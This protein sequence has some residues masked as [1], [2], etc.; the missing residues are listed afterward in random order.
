[1]D[2]NLFDLSIKLYDNVK[3]NITYISKDAEAFSTLIDNT[4]DLTIIHGAIQH[5]RNHISR[6]QAESDFYYTT[7]IEYPFKTR[8]FM[9]TRYSDGC[10]PV[11]YGSMTIETTLHETIYHVSQYLTAIDGITE[12]SIIIRKRSLYDVFCDTLLINLVN[13]TTDYPDLISNDYRYTQTI[14]QYINKNGYSGIFSRSARDPQGENVNIFKQHVLSSP[15]HL[16]FLR[17]TFNFNTHIVSIDGLEQE[18]EL[19]L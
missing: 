16:G 6:Q 8:P 14:G 7:A 19:A 10:Y 11:W 13:K 9:Q 15:T 4:Y 1:M 5:A 17:Y 18:L 12:E 3:R 2:K